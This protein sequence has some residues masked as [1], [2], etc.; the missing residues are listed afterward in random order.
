MSD[1]VDAWIGRT[2]EGRYRIDGKLGEGGMGAVYRAEHLKLGRPVAV[3]VLLPQYLEQRGLRQRFER[4]AKVLASVSNAHIV[5]L[6]DYGLE[7][8]SPYLVMELLEG[9][10]LRDRMLRGA[11]SVTDALGLMAQL[12]EGLAYAH[13]Q[14]MIHRDLK[15]ANI[16]LQRVPHRADVVRILDFGLAKF[17]TG[18]EHRDGPALTGTGVVSGTPAYMAPEQAAGGSCDAT[19]DVYATGVLLFELLASRRPFVGAP[20]EVV[21]KHLLELAPTLASVAPTLRPSVALEALVARALAKERKDR[22]ASATELL[23]ALLALPEAAQLPGRATAPTPAPSSVIET[24]DL[25]EQSATGPSARH[26]SAAEAAPTMLRPGSGGVALMP[27]KSSGLGVRVFAV[28]MVAGALC[29]GGYATY[30]LVLAPPSEPQTLGSVTLSAPDAAEPMD[31]AP[32]AD[33]PTPA[34]TEPHVAASAL[35]AASPTLPLVAPTLPVVEPP[36]ATARPAPRNP[37]AAGVPR[38]LRA[39]KALTDRGR[40]LSERNPS[41]RTERALRAWNAAHDGDARAALLLARVYLLRGWRPNAVEWYGKALSKDPGCGGAPHVATDL[42]ALATHSQGGASA[43][44]LIQLRLGSLAL[45][46]L[47]T[48]L[49]EPNLSP[50]DRATLETLRMLVV[51]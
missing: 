30:K 41:A 8:G 49:T 18:D 14:G 4:E 19:A 46:A 31:E 39:T 2:L 33:A 29:L 10:T 13:A 32:I 1:V 37:W 7:A 27:P 47:I 44:E 17:A 20:H 9:E 6:L 24:R 16:F 50:N 5:G 3:K 51:R 21:R 48:R 38:E 12:L 42:V 34:R 25:R 43:R 36:S 40:P 26:V 11:I 28:M 23:A 45:P 22:Y 15:P 35:P